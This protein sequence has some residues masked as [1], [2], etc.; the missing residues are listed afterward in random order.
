MDWNQI[1]EVLVDETERTDYATIAL[2]QLD[3]ST[4]YI[5]GSTLELSDRNYVQEAFANNSYVSDMLISRAINEP[6]AMVS[7]PIQRDGEIVGALIARMLGEDVINIITDVQLK[8]DG[9]AFMF[10]NAGTLVA[11]QNR[12]YVMEQLNPIQENNDM[13]RGLAEYMNSAINNQ[14][15]FSSYNFDGHEFY[16]GYT[17]VEGTDWIVS[18]SASEDE[19]LAG[20]NRMRNLIIIFSSII[21]ILALI[22]VYYFSN[23][24]TKPIIEVSNYA[25]KIADGDLSQKVSEKLL[26]KKDE[27]GQLAN[28]FSDM[29]HKLKS[30]IVQVIDI[31]GNLSASSQELSASG[32]EV[33]A[34]A[35]NVGQAIQDVAS[36]AEEQS[37][38]VEEA[39]SN[40]DELIVQ[41]EDVKNNSNQMNNQADKVMNNI[42]EGNSSIDE[43]VM[44]IKNVKSNSNEVSNTINKLGDLSEKIG[45]IIDLINKIQNSVKDAIGKMN[46]NKQV[47]DESVNAIDTTGKA[48]QKIN[49]AAVNLRNLIE[50]ISNNADI[51]NQNSNE[52]DTSI[53]EIASVSQ[54]AASNSE[55]V[56]SASE[57][58]SASTEEIVSAAEELANMA[59]NLTE[60]VNKFKI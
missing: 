49:N 30:L 19:V 50:E 1:Q 23:K 53:K 59:N 16:G 48:F 31:A 7:V 28:A 58:Q 41:I 45:E 15:G 2:V 25:K 46:N 29:N 60:A 11:H 18:V 57:E 21:L 35:E 6:V 42:N 40:V 5:D 3:G 22:F 39:T 55:E 14:S 24:I 32:E 34:S 54:E 44:K 4:N 27:I 43:S 13:Y 47:V 17:E 37:A 8:E 56:A 26:R 10:N 12:D 52:I 36:G 51:V 38:Q 9:S 20:L 33:A